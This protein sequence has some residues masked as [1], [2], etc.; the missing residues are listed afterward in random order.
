MTKFTVD[1]FK[2]ICNSYGLIVDE[3]VD[4]HGWT[5]AVKVH[6]HGI[7]E[8]ITS[9]TVYSNQ[10]NF[11]INIFQQNNGYIRTYSNDEDDATINIRKVFNTREVIIEKMNKMLTKFNENYKTFIKEKRK[12][13][14][15]EL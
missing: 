6:K 11:W 7:N 3:C 4:S 13:M 1:D 10:I 12:K 8:T 15:E 14:I 2:D 5:Y 9:F